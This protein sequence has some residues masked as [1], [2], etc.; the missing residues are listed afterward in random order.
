MNITPNYGL[1]KPSGEFYY[2]VEDQNYNMG[3]IDEEMKRLSLTSDSA[4]ISERILNA[5]VIYE[6]GGFILTELPDELPEVF[7]VRFKSP[8]TYMAGDV[9]NINSI[10]VEAKLHNLEAA[11]DGLFKEN[12]IVT[13]DV[14]LAD[15]IAFFNIG[16]AT[17]TTYTATIP[18]TG[19]TGSGP[20]TQTV[21]VPG[22]LEL[23]CPI[24]DALLSEVAQTALEQIAAWGLINRI[25]TGASTI[26]AYCYGD[27]P[28][29][30]IVLQ[31]KVVR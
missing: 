18:T 28:E 30:D 3:I 22:I 5:T 31:F 24:V 9:F 29:I 11:R 7:T 21:A 19:W 16:F 20:Y 2:D 26:T 6:S 23:D 14:D 4:D 8:A 10:I 15:N 25:I 13:M 1:K 12:A 17:T 27:K